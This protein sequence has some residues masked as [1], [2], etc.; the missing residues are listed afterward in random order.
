MRVEVPRNIQGLVQ[1]RD[2]AEFIS[3]SEETFRVWR[4]RRQTWIEQG[5]PPSKAIYTLLPEPVKDPEQPNEP[6][7]FNGAY[8]YY[9]EDVVKLRT[10]LAGHKSRAGNPEWVQTFERKEKRG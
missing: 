6:F 3:V 1:P 2:L 7:M 4:S 8:A 5:R 9:V 10:D